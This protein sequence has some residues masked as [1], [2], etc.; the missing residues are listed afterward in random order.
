MNK[1]SLT[2]LLRA[3]IV[4]SIIIVSAIIIYYFFKLLYPFIIAAFI[5]I[6]INPIINFLQEKARFPRLLA[7]LTTLLLLFSAFAGII[8]LL[9]AEI[10]SGT[11]YLA[12]VVPDKV[13]SIITT[14]QRFFT[15]KIVPFYENIASQFNTLDASKQDTITSSIKEASNKF[16][17]SVTVFLQDFLTS[18]PALI[19]WIPGAATA[20]VFILLATF[21]I[22]KDWRKLSKKLTTSLPNKVTKRTSSV[23]IDLKQAGAGFIKAQFVLITITFIIILSALLILQIE[24]AL[25]IALIIAIVDLLPY[26][27]TSAILIPWA[28]YEMVAGSFG[29][30]LTLAI[31]FVVVAGTRQFIEP[32][33]LSSSLNLDPLA[34]LIALFVGFK[35]F[36]FLGLIIGPI[37]LVFGTALHRTGV[38]RDIYNYIV[39]PNE[40]HRL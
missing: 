19:S 33:V 16:S 18:L 7:V 29:L 13:N 11:A 4:L 31:L 37:G 15:D 28:V 14:I 21:F 27:G 10:I 20:I 12:N 36:G 3:L 6:L 26:L 22:S 35:L 24:H 38:Y 17:S 8:T 25:T 9:I 34:T 40:D 5:V 39:Q 32:K 23:L 2:I 30:G 1:K